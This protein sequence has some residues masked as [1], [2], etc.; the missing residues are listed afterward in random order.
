MGM[1]VSP[2]IFG[3]CPAKHVVSASLGN[4]RRGFRV[5]RSYRLDGQFR[6]SADSSRICTRRTFPEIVLGIVSTNS[7]MRGYL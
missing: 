5:D 4:L 7:T 2:C 1:R 3:N 6:Q